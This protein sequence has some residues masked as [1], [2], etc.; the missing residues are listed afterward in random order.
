MKGLLK[1]NRHQL[2]A[3]ENRKNQNHFH[4]SVYPIALRHWHLFLLSNNQNFR[5]CLL[6]YHP[7]YRNRKCLL[8]Y[9]RH[10]LFAEEKRVHRSHPRQSVYPIALRHWHQF[11]L[12]N[13]R[14]FRGC[15]LFYRHQYR[16]GKSLLK[17]S[18]HQLFA[19][20]KRDNH[21]QFLQN[22]YPIA[23]LHSHQFLLSN[24]PH[25]RGYL[26]FYHHQYQKMR[27]LL[28][29]SRHQLFFTLPVFLLNFL[30]PVSEESQRIFLFLS[31]KILCTFSLAESS[32]A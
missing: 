17:Y 7:Q 15:L 18:R 27:R 3:E 1:Y 23:L 4:Q 22:V 19:E 2:F 6:F 13:N 8:K 26:V 11:L 32:V 14:Y 29:Y 30:M 28:K 31:F 24:N 5:G 21:N 20:E 9:S 10:Q 16:R 25:V 12:S